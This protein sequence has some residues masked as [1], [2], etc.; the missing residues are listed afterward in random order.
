MISLKDILAAP[1]LQDNVA[2]MEH[3]PQINIDTYSTLDSVTDHRLTWVKNWSEDIYHRLEQYHD[4]VVICNA[5]DA[6]LSNSNYYI[7]VSNPK[8][9][10]FELLA[11]FFE[12]KPK[13]EIADTAVVKTDRIGDNPSIGDYAVISEETIIGDN[14]T[15]GSHVRTIGR[16]EIGDNVVIQSGTVI[17]EASFGYYEGEDGHYHRVPQLGGVVIHNDVEI[18]ANSTID[19]GTMDDTVIGAHAKIG[20]LVHVAHNVQIGEDALLISSILFCGSSS[21][22]AGSYIAPG[23]IIMN[24]KHVGD[25]AL[26]GMGAMVIDDVKDGTVVAGVP[27]KYLRENK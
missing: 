7:T 9:V 20:N 5:P 19:R 27:A 17:G 26:V 24:Q 16:V 25:H 23:S 1:P 11:Y 14:V 12:K 8:A 21:V 18:G 10:F 4:L 6:V 2:G 15:I 13:R 3:I 22:G